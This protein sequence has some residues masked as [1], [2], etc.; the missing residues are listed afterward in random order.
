MK[1]NE[2]IT[3]AVI[4]DLLPAY[5]EGLC[6]DET[7]ALVEAHLADCAD[8]SELLKALPLPEKKDAA[9]PTEK[10]AF[11]KVSRKLR[12]HKIVSGVL[13]C[14]IAAAL[15]VLAVLSVNQMEKQAP[16]FDTIYARQEAKQLTKLLTTG[17]YD[18]FL[19][20][21]TRYNWDAISF[22][23]H[24]ESNAYEAQRRTLLQERYEAAY[25][26]TEVKDIRIPETGYSALSMDATDLPAAVVCV[27]YTDGR[28]LELSFVHNSI[29][30]WVVIG[31]GELY[32]DIAEH[33]G[34]SLTPE[35]AFDS[36]LD[37]LTFYH[38]HEPDFRAKKLVRDEEFSDESS[39]KNMAFLMFRREQ[40]TDLI[41]SANAFY[42]HEGF[43]ITDAVYS[44]LRWDSEKDM[45]YFEAFLTAAD[46][47]GTAVLNTRIYI[48]ADGWIAP[49]ADMGSVTTDGCT[50]A[51]T[52]ALLHFFG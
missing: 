1:N 51:L 17:Q 9:V 5:T 27:D 2:K 4:E 31:L 12:F 32:S 41:D 44:N 11:K 39:G 40:Q 19:M 15:I 22:G 36:C 8:C 21:V 29:G 38:T 30:Q 24:E 46:T 20:R 35:M 48:D 13:T 16:S 37:Y 10:K 25:G 14:L 49:T 43:A 18:T 23:G 6:N 50:P 26:N 3:C 33:S 7:K 34:E 52:E 45:I 28:T 42:A 47:E